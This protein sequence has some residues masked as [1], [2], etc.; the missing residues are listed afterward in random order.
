MTALEK[1]VALGSKI[2]AAFKT[3]PPVISTP[4]AK[5]NQDLEAEMEAI[6]LE[7]DFYHVEGDTLTGGVVISKFSDRVD[8]FDQLNNRVV[9]IVPVPSLVEVTKW[10]DDTTQTVGVYPESLRD[11]LLDPFAL[12]GVQR[13]VSLTGGDP[14]QIFHDMHTLPPGMPHDG[15]EPLRRNVRWVID[16]RAPDN[17]VNFAIAAE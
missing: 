2:V 14:M 3:L 5:R 12:A 1:L 10:C 17:V 6:S 11:T 16:Q 15:I 8:F 7:D 4:V 13:L 9:N